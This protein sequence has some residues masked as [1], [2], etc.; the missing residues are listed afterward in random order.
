MA[1]AIIEAPWTENQVATLNAFQRSGVAHPFTCER[2]HTLHQTLIAES[3]GWHCPDPDCSFTQD[4]AM[5]I[6]ADPET[7]ER[8]I[9]TRVVLYHTPTLPTS[10]DPVAREM[11]RLRME[12]RETQD[13]LAD[14]RGLIA[15]L[16]QQKRA[17]QIVLSR[18]TQAQKAGLSP[19]V[20]S[21]GGECDPVWIVGITGGRLI[22]DN[23]LPE[24][25]EGELNSEG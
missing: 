25:S 12:L 4:W 15:S 22:E 19:V 10:N 17:M 9:R 6:M 13:Q 8:L 7:L 23:F 3:D 11:R 5:S 21:T 20:S 1:D 18:V 2:D 16:S 14:A 24:P